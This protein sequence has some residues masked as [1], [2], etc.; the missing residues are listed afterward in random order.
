MERLL[1]MMEPVVVIHKLGAS[2]FEMALTLTVY[3]RSL[4]TAGGQV[5][6]AQTASSRFFLLH[7]VISTMAA[8]LSIVPLGRVADRRG[9]KVF[10]VVSQLGSVLGMCFLLLFLFCDLPVEFLFLGTAVYGLCGGSPAYWAGVVAL[11]ALSSRRRSRTLKLNVV[12]MCVGVAGVL[13][14]LLSGYVY[15]VGHQGAVLLGAA[16]TLSTLSL[17]LSVFFLP[18]PR[19]D[20]EEKEELLREPT[21][22]GRPDAAAGG[23]LMT[24]MVVFILG[25]VGAEDVLTLYVLKPPLSWDSVWAGY[26]SAATNAMYVS[27][28]LGVLVLSRVL[29]DTALSL[30]GIM[31]NCTGMAIMAFTVESWIY[32]LARG[33]MMF[34][35]VPM[36]T[37]RA[38]LSKVLDSQ[39]YGRTFGRLQLVLAVTELVS[40]VFFA[41]VYPLTL[42]SC[43]GVWF[44]LSCAISYLSVIPILYLKFRQR[45]HE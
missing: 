10:L 25:M 7:S 29:G 36:P 9:P 34:A 16:I 45:R 6:Q 22:E 21:G 19:G 28:F 43:S 13:G 39:Q 8:M 35:C 14:G 42:H 11:A 15:R 5:E 17:L 1:N 41:S 37:L 20:G 3:N 30:L 4:E 24:A 31:S 18:T 32:F 26:G 44:L 38:M 12:D 27:S 23:L 33:I 40:T 2:F